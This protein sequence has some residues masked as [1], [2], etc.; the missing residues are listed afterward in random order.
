MDLRYIST[1]FLCLKFPFYMF[2][3][4]CLHKLRSSFMS[5]SSYHS[6]TFSFIWYCNTQPRT[7]VI[8]LLD[9]LVSFGGQYSVTFTKIEKR[10]NMSLKRN[11]EISS[12]CLEKMPSYLVLVLKTGIFHTWMDISTVYG[13]KIDFVT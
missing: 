6:S 1:P 9:N 3:C 13:P 11:P 4:S 2:A 5:R 10:A 8:S 7:L 12:A